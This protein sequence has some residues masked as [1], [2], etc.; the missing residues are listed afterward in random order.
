MKVALISYVDY[1]DSGKELAN[2]IKMMTDYEVCYAKCRYETDKYFNAVKGADII[3]CKGDDPAR[4]EKGVFYMDRLRGKSH[5]MMVPPCKCKKKAKLI[6]TASGSF[7]RRKIPGAKK[8]F[9][10]VPLQT[11][12][13]SFDKITAL[14]P[15]LNYP[16]LSGEWLPH[17]W[18]IKKYRNAWK[19]SKTLKINTYTN[20]IDS[21]EVYTY[22]MPAVEQLRNE[23][24]RIEVTITQGVSIKQSLKDKREATLYFN[25]ITPQG[26][27]GKSVVEAL[28]YGIP[29]MCH[30]STT[31]VKQAKPYKRYGKVCLNVSDTGEVIETL[32]DI[33]EGRINM[34]ELSKQSRGYAI[35][36]HSY[37]TVGM[38]AKRI[39]EEVIAKC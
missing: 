16:I 33:L 10:K 34:Q 20:N 26:V 31:A 7:F 2:A 32:R 15:D 28:S 39:I 22:L 19:N 5:K 9:A 36:Y 8:A 21:K 12:I 23:G 17:A 11:Y 29:V 1:A 38:Q 35:K 30:I 18:D 13:R 4:I 14:S 24:H 3:W 37:E 25:S 27:Y 6:L